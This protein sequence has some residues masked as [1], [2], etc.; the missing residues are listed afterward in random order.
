MDFLGFR[1]LLL[2]ANFLAATFATWSL[3]TNTTG[4]SPRS[5][6]AAAW[7]S[8]N[9]RFWVHAGCGESLLQ[10]DLWTFD[11]QG[12]SWDLIPDNGWRPSA[13]E[14]HV[15]VW[16][17]GGQVFWIH[18][19]F[20]GSELLKDVWKFS[21]TLWTLVVDSTIPGPA[22]SNHVAMWDASNSALW[23]HGGYAYDSNSDS[24]LHDDMW[25]FETQKSS[26]TPVSI[27]QVPSARA[28]HVATW[29]ETNS[30]I[31]LHGGFDGSPLL[32]KEE[33]TRTCF[34]GLF[35]LFKAWL[36]RFKKQTWPSLCQEPQSLD[37]C[38][39]GCYLDICLLR[40]VKPEDKTRVAPS[41]QSM[42]EV[43][44]AVRV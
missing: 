30:N 26:W 23:I 12:N 7:D 4:P 20:D 11:V 2:W 37:K 35:V 16:D 40:F 1:A 15:A 24:V 34:F 27:S 39:M 44:H 22:R 42:R 31:W 43:L 36:E 25:K 33:Q 21:G 19:G 5:V 6:H 14:D 32:G 17:P 10:T 41:F 3:V 18:G 9:Q 28:Y 29:D 8:S 38:A 13:R